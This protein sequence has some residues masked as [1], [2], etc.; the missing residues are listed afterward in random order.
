[1]C[2]HRHARHTTPRERRD[3][4][5]HAGFFRSDDVGT[6]LRVNVTALHPHGP[7]VAVQLMHDRHDGLWLRRRHDEGAREGEAGGGHPRHEPVAMAIEHAVGRIHGDRFA[8][9]ELQQ[10]FGRRGTL[11]HVHVQLGGRQAARCDI[12]FAAACHGPAPLFQ[13]DDRIVEDR[14][15]VAA[16]RLGRVGGAAIERDQSLHRALHRA[17]SDAFVPSQV[18]AAS[19]SRL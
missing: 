4:V 8:W 15:I 12:A 6:G 11:T 13:L 19:R 1:M 2:L 18:S 9:H 14:R 16:V 17:S 10:P 5:G 7:P 3:R